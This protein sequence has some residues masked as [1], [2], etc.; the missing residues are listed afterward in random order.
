M[1]TLL[2][3][4]EASKKGNDRSKKKDGQRSPPICSHCGIKGSVVDQCYKLHGYPRVT[5][6]TII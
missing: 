4:V 2:V 5:N 3:A 1:N 6:L